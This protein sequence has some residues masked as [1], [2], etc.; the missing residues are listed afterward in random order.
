M[1]KY[2]FTIEEES[3]G[4]RIDIFLSEQI[5]NVSRSYAQKL[6]VDNCVLVNNKEIKPN[7]KLKCKDII[8]ITIPDP[9]ELSVSADHNIKLEILFEDSDIIVINKPQGLVVHPAPGNYEGTL[10]NALMSHCGDSLSEINGVIR[11]G[12]VHRIDKDTSGVLVVA[13]NNIS[14]I[15]LA[16][17]IK[18]HTV[19]RKYIAIVNGNIKEQQ[20]TINAPIGRHAINRKKMTVTEK[21]SREA[22]T[23]FL[24]LE[25]FGDYTLIEAKLETGRTHQIRVHMAYIKHPVLGDSVYGPKKC[26]FNLKGQVLHAK[27]LGFIHP[28]KNKYVEFQA[29]NPKYFDNIIEILRKENIN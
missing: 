27:I 13:K 7:Y 1:Q 2:V 20:G 5:E 19:T 15:S 10:V 14:H 9:K 17:Q 29:P 8:D 21:A 28:T 26:K 4:V 18:D 25:R 16:K 6:I 23:H 11:P 12:I 3:C 22:V 24:V